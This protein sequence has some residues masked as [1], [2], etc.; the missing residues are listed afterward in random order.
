MP[1]MVILKFNSQLPIK[2]NIILVGLTREINSLT[3]RCDGDMSDLDTNNT[4]PLP[5]YDH[6]DDYTKS[7]GKQ[8]HH[9]S[10]KRSGPV[11]GSRG[12]ETRSSKR[13]Q[14][15]KYA[16]NGSIISNG[17]PT[18]INPQITVGALEVMNVKKVANRYG[19]LPKGDRIGAFLESL[20]GNTPNNLIPEK[21]PAPQPTTPNGNLTAA[22]P[23]TP[24]M[25]RSNSSSGVT[26][27]NNASASLIKLQR[28]RTT[29]DGGSFMTFSSFRGSSSSSPKKS[30]NYQRELPPPDLEFP[31]PPSDLPPPLI[32][33]FES[34]QSLAPPPPPQTQPMHTLQP[35][36]SVMSSS[37]VNDVSNTAPSVEEASSRFGVSLRKREQSSDCSMSPRSP[38]A[39]KESHR[40]DDNPMTNSVKEKLEMKFLSEMKELKKEENFHLNGN[41]SQNPGMQLVNEMMENMQKSGSEYDLFLFV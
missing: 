36:T 37:S 8:S 28:H 5:N 21:E 31:P 10:F 18:M 11:L 9:S 17:E 3:N 32:E 15:S 20:E 30:L 4:H 35:P 41:I 2:S 25:I 6:E 1:Q 39:D 13:S 16:T 26:M 40:D 27:A 19:T 24:Q 22:Q 29:T 7:L 23:N 34:F 33:D 38:S 14:H 12:L